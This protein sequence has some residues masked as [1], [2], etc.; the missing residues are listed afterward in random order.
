VYYASVNNKLVSIYMCEKPQ[1][2]PDIKEL[3]H[4]L[5]S[6]LCNYWNKDIFIIIIDDFKLNYEKKRTLYKQFLITLETGKNYIDK[7][8]VFIHTYR[9]IWGVD[10]NDK[11]YHDIWKKYVRTFSSVERKIIVQY[12]YEV[13]YVTYNEHVMK[14]IMHGPGPVPQ[15]PQNK[16]VKLENELSDTRAQIDQLTGELQALTQLY[17]EEKSAHSYTTQRIKDLTTLNA[18][19]QSLVDELTASRNLYRDLYRS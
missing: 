11:I 18:R 3:N 4:I 10:A 6:K 16:I 15:Q 2:M 12:L 17:T 8:K 13:L 1:C 19:L 7:V 14:D 5:D 9:H